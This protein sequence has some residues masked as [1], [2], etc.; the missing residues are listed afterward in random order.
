MSNKLI[1]EGW[2][3]L[4][5]ISGETCR[6]IINSYNPA[7]YLDISSIYIPLYKDFSSN[8]FSLAPL[9]QVTDISVSDL[10]FNE[11]IGSILEYNN[12]KANLFG[13]VIDFSNITFSENVGFWVYMKL[14]PTNPVLH[15]TITNP[16]IEGFPTILSIDGDTTFSSPIQFDFSR[17]DISINLLVERTFNFKYNNIFTSVVV[18][19]ND[20]TGFNGK[21]GNSNNN[22]I[23]FINILI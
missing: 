12:Y 2:Y 16:E 11:T 17:N 8:I 15:L 13:R 5:G 19:D 23:S 4:S 21:S 18:S 14:I 22:D 7:S 9:N 3:L 10:V 1:E 6:N 20:Y